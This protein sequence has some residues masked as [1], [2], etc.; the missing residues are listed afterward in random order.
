[1]QNIFKG[2]DLFQDAGF[3]KTQQL[4]IWTLHSERASRKGW[5]LLA[6]PGLAGL[7]QTLPN[8]QLV[9]LM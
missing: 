8:L 2:A 4:F 3:Q 1:M 9:D 6:T 5:F 7:T